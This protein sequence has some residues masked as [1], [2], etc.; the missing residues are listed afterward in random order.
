VHPVLVINDLHYDFSVNEPWSDG[1]AMEAGA[2]AFYCWGCF[3]TKGALPVVNQFD[4]NA[5]FSTFRTV[6]HDG[7]FYGRRSYVIVNFTER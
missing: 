4:C 6:Q 5:S 2:P 3:T 7:T 1:V